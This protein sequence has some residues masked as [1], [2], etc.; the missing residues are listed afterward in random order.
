MPE[1]INYDE[2][3]DGLVQKTDEGK[4]AW[5]QVYSENNFS[6]VLEGGEFTFKVEKR[7]DHDADETSLSLTMNDNQ[8]NEIFRVDAPERLALGRKLSNLHESARRQALDVE[9]KISAVKNI[10]KKI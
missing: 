7:Y 3:V 4:I 6:C 5:S 1:P 8:G 9:Q 10:L 2:I